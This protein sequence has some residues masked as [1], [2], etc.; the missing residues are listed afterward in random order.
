MLA[1]KETGVF[2]VP[3]I[4]VN[5]ENFAP[6]FAERNYIAEAPPLDLCAEDVDKTVDEFRTLVDGKCVFAVHSGTYCRKAFYEEPFLEFYRRAVKNGGEICVHTHEEIAGKGTRN[7]DQDHVTRVIRERKADLVNAG[8]TPTSYRGG[9]FAYME[10]LTPL[11]DA[12]ELLVDFSCA[13]EFNEPRWDAVWVGS[14]FSAYYLCPDDRVKTDCATPSRVLEIP[15]AADGLGWSPTNYLYTDESNDED[16]R[17][18]WQAVRDRAEKEGAPQVVD[19]I[20]HSSSMHRPEIVE[21][22][23]SFMD[24]VASHGATFV[25]PLEAKQIYDTQLAKLAGAR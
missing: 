4:D 9:H 17:R 16:L 6:M 7:H 11:L 18:V 19:M 23:R 3:L 13:P 5:W 14:P 12:E 10:Y 22:L 21:R 20:F 25:T 1:L 24:H 8:I 15:V 2:L